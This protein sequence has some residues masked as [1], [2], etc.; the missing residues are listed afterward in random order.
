MEKVINIHEAKTHFSKLVDQVAAGAE[1]VIGKAGQP[2]VKLVPYQAAPSSPRTGGQLHGK[3]WEAADCW[4]ADEELTAA[5]TG[6]AVFPPE[7]AST[8]RAA[9]T[10]P[11]LA[12]HSQ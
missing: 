3:I 11:G 12:V 8:L 5:L 6:G 9:E 1:L 2:L 7:Y 10:P 4:D